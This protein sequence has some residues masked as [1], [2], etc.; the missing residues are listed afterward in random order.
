MSV[1][2]TAVL[3]LVQFVRMMGR[4]AHKADSKIRLALNHELDTDISYGCA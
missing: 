2:F 4:R 1:T 3:S